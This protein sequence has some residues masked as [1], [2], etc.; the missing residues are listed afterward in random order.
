MSFKIDIKSLIFGV[1]IGFTLL[2][3]LGAALDKKTAGE[4]Q[5]SMAAD[6]EYLYFGRMHTGT[7]RIE[8]W[9]FIQNHPAVQHQRYDTILHEPDGQL[10]PSR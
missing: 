1:L 2:I 9:K 3:S 6:E 5:L 10:A 8:T 4:Y 7:G